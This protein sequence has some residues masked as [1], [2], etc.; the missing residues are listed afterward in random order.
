MNPMKEMKSYIMPKPWLRMIGICLCVATLV[1]CILGLAALGSGDEADAPFNP[2]DT[3]VGTMAYLDVVGVSDWLYNYDGAVYYSAEDDEG[4]FYT[5]RLTDAQHEEMAAQQAYWTR[6]TE[7]APQPEVYRLEGYVQEISDDTRQSLADCWDISTGEYEQ[8]FGDLY[9]NATTTSGEQNSG[10]WFFFALFTA[11]FAIYFFMMSGRSSKTAKKC[12]K[13]LEELGLLDRAAEE[14]A[15]ANHTVVGKDRARLSGRFIYS[16]GSGVVVAY[17][18]ILWC[19]KMN[20]RRNFAVTN[21]YLTV[22]TRT[23]KD[24]PAV[25]FGKND[26]KGEIENALAIIAQRNPDTLIGYSQQNGNAYRE[27]VRHK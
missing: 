9:L 10:P 19:Y 25:N 3:K 2:L 20:Q 12:L 17:E 24:L 14:F 11:L 7:D 5:V 1:L 23:L 22:Y 13:R 26:R 8:Y 18:D 15:S 4:Y 27:M 6:E 21:T 16:H